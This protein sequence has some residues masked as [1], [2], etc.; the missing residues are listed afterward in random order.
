M[1]GVVVVGLQKMELRWSNLFKGTWAAKPLGYV[2]PFLEGCSWMSLVKA[3]IEL[4]SAR[5]GSQ[6][7]IVDSS[8]KFDARGCRCDGS[9]FI[10]LALGLS[11]DPHHNKLCDAVELRDNVWSLNSMSGL[12]VMTVDQGP[13]R[14]LHLKLCGGL[15]SPRQAMAWFGIMMIRN[16]SGNYVTFQSLLP[17]PHSKIGTPES[18]P[19][20]G[21]ISLCFSETLSKM[22]LALAVRWACYCEPIFYGETNRENILPVPQEVLRVREDAIADLKIYDRALLENEVGKCFD[23][24]DLKLKIL[25]ALGK[26]GIHEEAVSSLGPL[27]TLATAYAAPDTPQHCCMDMRVFFDKSPI[28]KELHAKVNPYF[29]RAW[30]LWEEDTHQINRGTTA[31]AAKIWL[32][33]SVIQL[34]PRGGWKNETSIDGSVRS[35]P[36]NT[37]LKRLLEDSDAKSDVKVYID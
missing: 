11:V 1:T 28:L 12:E 4:S 33:L 31:T 2:D 3:G 25:A 18:P 7:L 23:D 22:S 9:T 6:R 10:F 30:E 36:D 24:A 32:A 37:I 26:I 35:R 15:Y 20:V 27:H 34:A 5:N 29:T 13:S 14:A 16:N 21:K 17:S 8:L 19:N